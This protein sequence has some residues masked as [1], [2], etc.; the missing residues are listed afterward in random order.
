MSNENF[1]ATLTAF[2]AAV[3]AQDLERLNSV[4]LIR[5]IEL[6]VSGGGSRNP[7]MFREIVRRCRGMSVRRIEDSGIPAQAR[8]A[9]S[10]ALLAWWHI[11]SY[12]GNYPSI[13]GVK[14][15]VVLGTRVNPV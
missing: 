6:L 2:S 10:F 14:R 3:I 1:M 13:T 5:P 15:S 4:Q 9:M 11:A 12:S 7:I 8:E